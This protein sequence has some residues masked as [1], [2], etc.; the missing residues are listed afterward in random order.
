MV[1][2]L[3][4]DRAPLVSGMATTPEECVDALLEA[5]DRLGESPTKAAYE[6]LGLTPASA[7]IIRVMGSWNDAK[8]MTNLKT[9]PSTGSRVRPPP[10]GVSIP[11]GVDWSDLTVDQRWHYRHS[12]RNARRTLDRRRRLRNWLRIHKST[13]G[14][15]ACGESEPACLDF[16]HVTGEKERSVTE[17]ITFGYSAAAIHQEIEK[18]E[19]LCA[20]CH[21][22]E[23]AG[24]AVYRTDGEGATKEDRMRAWTARYCRRRG[25]RRC[26][27][28][29]ASKLVFHHP[30]PTAK[31]EAIGAMVANS[32][33]FSAV[34]SEAR[35]CV[36][37]CA[38]CHRKEH[39]STTLL[40][41]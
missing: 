18:C 38:N 4:A 35:R 2:G 41:V 11:E 5:A 15:S 17:M 40:D 16:H 24:P 19:V 39:D 7:T 1:P 22:H 29:Q 31:D 20:N 37:L 21:R 26:G 34:K 10:E 6:E 28:R 30:E 13:L 27:E 3:K 25:C 23:H 32:R 36:V 14:C 8:R 12:D 33:D 9:E